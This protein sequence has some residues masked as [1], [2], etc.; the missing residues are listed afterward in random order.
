[1]EKILMLEKIEG[2]RRKERQRMRW[3]D[4]IIDSM[5]MS[6]SKLWALV[7]ERRP[8]VLQ[9]MGSH[10]VAYERLNCNSVSRKAFTTFLQYFKSSVEVTG[11]YKM[12]SPTLRMSLRLAC[13]PK[14]SASAHL[15]IAGEL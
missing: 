4:G 5:N 13:C 1:M 7:M 3:L 15:T 6:L 2:R 9:S 12:L 8:G 11:C 14:P 10:R